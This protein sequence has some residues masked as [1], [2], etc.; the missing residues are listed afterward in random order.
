MF[1]KNVFGS[2]NT[3]II[4]FNKIQD[5]YWSSLKAFL[6]VLGMMKAETYPHIAIDNVLMNRLKEE[7]K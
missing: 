2:Y 4:L 6:I 3:M 1:M 5:K 7:L